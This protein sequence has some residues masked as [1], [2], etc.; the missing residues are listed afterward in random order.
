VPITCIAVTAFTQGDFVEDPCSPCGVCRQ[1]ILE[2][3]TRSGKPIK[4]MLVG[5]SKI[6]VLDTVKDLLPLCFTEF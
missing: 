5:K 6:Y 2:F 4:V 3:E 1:A